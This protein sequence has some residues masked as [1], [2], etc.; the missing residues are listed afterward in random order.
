MRGRLWSLAQRH[1]DWVLSGEA[2]SD[3]TTQERDM[4]A[5]VTVEDRNVAAK[6]VTEHCIPKPKAQLGVKH[7]G[8]GDAVVVEVRTLAPEEKA[9][10]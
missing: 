10:G 9:N 4:Y 3:A 1:L 5:G 6:L 8:R 7:E 2:P